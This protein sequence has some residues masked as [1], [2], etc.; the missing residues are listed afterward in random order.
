MDLEKEKK[1]EK[2][3]S[4]SDEYGRAFPFLLVNTFGEIEITLKGE[5]TKVKV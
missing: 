2:A 4:R 3:Q 5:I 1:Q